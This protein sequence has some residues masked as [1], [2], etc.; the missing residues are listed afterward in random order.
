MHSSEEEKSYDRVLVIARREASWL[1]AAVL[2]LIMV[3]FVVGYMVGQR[4]VVRD[5]VHNV[6]LAT[7]LEDVSE[8]DDADIAAPEKLAA[9]AA[10]ASVVTPVASAETQSSMSPAHVE[11]ALDYYA[12]LTQCASFKMAQGLVDKAARADISGLRIKREVIKKPRKK[13]VAVYH[14]LTA[15][16]K[17]KNSFDQDLAKLKQVLKIDTVTTHTMKRTNT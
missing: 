2:V 11:P 9:P 5:M 12:Q 10:S 7:S 17:N 1:V 4:L 8:Q 16:Y 15:V 3:A 14:V 6:Q 13:R